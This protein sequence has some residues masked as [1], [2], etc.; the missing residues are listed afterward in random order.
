[1]SSSEDTAQKQQREGVK[2]VLLG[3]PGAGKGTQA[4][5]LV[6]HYGVCQL[7]TGDMLREAVRNQTDVGKEAKAVMD[8]GGLVS[9]G[10]VVNLINENLDK[11][12]CQNG[13]LLDGFPRTLVQAKKLDDLLAVRKTKLDGC[14]EF[15][16]DD[17]LLIRRITG[18]LFHKAS[19]RTYHEEFNPPKKPM[20][21]DVTGEPLERRSDDNVEAL[22][23]RL[24]AYH[25]QTAPLAQYYA[26]NHIHRA[27]DASLSSSVVF[28]NILSGFD[29]L[30]RMARIAPGWVFPEKSYFGRMHQYEDNKEETR[31]M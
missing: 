5:K 14:I 2:A 7:S 10:I 15:K 21:D 13:F 9:D 6:D 19:G 3:P 24:E 11:K 30:K 28:K 4:A 27:V 18:R 1:M 12:E 22:A 31:S 8:A 20:I 17:D 26:K 29:S 23:K 25:A 16:I